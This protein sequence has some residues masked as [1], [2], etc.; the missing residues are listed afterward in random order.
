MADVELAQPNAVG[1]TKSLPSQSKSSSVD[2]E[3]SNATKD[4]DY[5]P[6]DIEVFEGDYG[7]L[8]KKATSIKLKDRFIRVTLILLVPVLFLSLNQV[9]KDDGLLSTDLLFTFGF[10]LIFMFVGYFIHLYTTVTAVCSPRLA[11]IGRNMEE[12]Q[13]ND[14]ESQTYQLKYK[15][16]HRIYSL[17]VIYP[18]WSAMN[19]TA[20]ALLYKNHAITSISEFS[21]IHGGTANSML[22]IIS[23]YAFAILIC[24]IASEQVLYVFIAK[25]NI[26]FFD[27]PLFF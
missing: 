24:G 8:A 12:V 4:S 13:Y 20:K 25:I 26:K 2:K 17:N 19:F 11:D 3:I 5:I 1:S 10:V 14:E 22:I 15:R 23:S 6:Y 18:S 16:L 9:F 7:D 21:A 27:Y